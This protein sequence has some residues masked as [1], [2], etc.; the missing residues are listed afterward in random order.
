MTNRSSDVTA[1]PGGV[2][3]DEVGVVTGD[4]T[5]QTEADDDGT[6]R[7]QVQY[8]GADESYTITG[9]PSS[10]DL[11]AVHAVVVDRVRRGGGG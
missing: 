9:A 10:G 5:V 7:C 1:G 4:L 3:T 2:M 8:Q 11:D 6:L